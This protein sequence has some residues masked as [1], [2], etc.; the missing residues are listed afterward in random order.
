MKTDDFIAALAADTLPRPRIAAQLARALSVALGVSALAFAYLWG[1][2]P[3]IGAAL[4][5][6]AVF[7]TLTPLVLLALGL[8]L[9]LALAHPGQRSDAK[10]AMLA[11]VVLGLVVTLAVT[12]F[13]QGTP[14]LANA[15]ATPTLFVCL[16]SI[17][18]L[19][20]PILGAV[21]WALS[22]GAV[23]QPRYAGAVAG[24]T[25]GA[26]AAAIY[27]LYCD[28]DMVLFVVPA[29]GTAILAVTLVGT[30]IAPRVLRW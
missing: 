3:D 13:Q 9:A 11:A 21:L 19:S 22:Y 18:A 7:K 24:L 23:L 15:L 5:S 20:V 29:Y 8:V 14:A 25:S 28:K 1:M 27:S 2:R 6:L 10:A 16:T 4:A 17:P 12:V 30:L 26:A